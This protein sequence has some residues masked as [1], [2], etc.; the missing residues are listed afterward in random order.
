MSLL[1]PG[2]TAPDFAL[3][4]T[5]G[6]SYSLA[7]ALARGPALL[8]F[9]KTTCATCD[10][11][12]PYIQRLLEAY[13]NDGW[14]LW[15]VSQSPQVETERYAGALQLT[16]PV[17]LDEPGFIVSDVYDPP[18]TPTL[19]LIDRMGK[20]LY[21]TYGFSKDDLNEASALMARQLRVQPKVIAEMGDGRPDFRPG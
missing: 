10:L 15:G 5:D 6:R 21:T 11:A 4:G 18:A 12:F 19:F 7:E 17:L 3:T 20:V 14:Q 2:A 1:Q 8:V 13:R 16:F 9:F